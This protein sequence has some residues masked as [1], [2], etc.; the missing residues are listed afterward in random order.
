MKTAKK[1]PL[2]VG[3]PVI[4]CISL[5]DPR[6]LP[7]FEKIISFYGKPASENRWG[8]SATFTPWQAA[9]TTR[10]CT[11]TFT[12]P[13]Q[14]EQ[15]G[16]PVIRTVDLKVGVV[17]GL[18]ITGIDGEF[19][20]LI[21]DNVHDAMKKAENPLFVVRMGVGIMTKPVITKHKQVNDPFERLIATIIM[22]YV[23]R[24]K[25]G[26]LMPWGDTPKIQQR[27]SRPAQRT[28]WKTH[29]LN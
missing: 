15:G 21:P 8:I 14:S 11:A 28:S 12:I 9:K 10:T 17:E 13:P 29:A 7:V 24:G 4:G 2:Q 22:N 1:D 6:L 16:E 3:T 27:S 5:A 23:V 26:E 25:R 20:S 19:F 18:H